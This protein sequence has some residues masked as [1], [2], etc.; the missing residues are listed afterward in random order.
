M[1]VSVTSLM[2]FS[3]DGFCEITPVSHACSISLLS[4][5][6]KRC[7][8]MTLWV[9]DPLQYR[10]SNTAVQYMMDLSEVCSESREILVLG[11]KIESQNSSGK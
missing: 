9:K 1:L 4:E 10:Y 5:F 3:P 6:Y 7:R 8:G 2:T 11:C